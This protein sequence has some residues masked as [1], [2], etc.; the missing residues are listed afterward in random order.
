MKTERIEELRLNDSDEREIVALLQEAFDTDFGGRSFYMQ[1][2]TARLVVRED[3]IVGHLGLMFR[4]VRVG[5]ALIPVL[6][7]GDV[8]TAPDR[9]GQGIAGALVAAAIE[10]GR[11]SPAKFLALFGE[12][13]VYAGAGFQ[14]KRNQMRWID[15]VGARTGEVRQAQANYLMIYPLTDMDWPDGELDLIGNLF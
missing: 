13:G 10:E 2:H 4:S 15:M 14:R 7:I 9:R 8:A 11:A 1:R 5:D 12:A 6:G 3:R